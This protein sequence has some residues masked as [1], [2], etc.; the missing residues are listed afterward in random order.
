MGQPWTTKLHDL[1]HKSAL[2]KHCRYFPIIPPFVLW[3]SSVFCSASS[4]KRTPRWNIRSTA[5]Q[6]LASERDWSFRS[7]SLCHQLLLATLRMGTRDSR[8]KVQA[9]DGD[10]R[11]GPWKLGTRQVKWWYPNWW[12]STCL[13]CN[14][15]QRGGFL[16]R[17]QLNSY[18]Y[19][20]H[21]VEARQYPIDLIILSRAIS[22]P[23]E[24]SATPGA[25]PLHL[26]QQLQQPQ[27]QGL[28]G[29]R[30]CH[31]HCTTATCRLV[32]G[33]WRVFL[34]HLTKS[35]WELE[36]KMDKLKNMGGIWGKKN[37]GHV[38]EEYGRINGTYTGK[39]WE[40]LGKTG[41]QLWIKNDVGRFS[42]YADWELLLQ[43]PCNYYHS[44]FIYKST[45]IDYLNASRFFAIQ[46]SSDQSMTSVS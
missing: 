26:A 2:F 22:N 23:Q 1:R 16:G 7:S 34:P 11:G 30:I 6:I 8:Y 25:R 29:R 43:V 21:I 45:V 32:P 20:H 37:Y 33:G 35:M 15:R 41:A 5:E 42:G 38:W 13:V 4:S 39:E 28:Q 18:T 31:R 14:H 44:Q 24:K 27:Q 36:T 12:S 46:S 10:F 3:I 17:K 19:I 40:I 9:L